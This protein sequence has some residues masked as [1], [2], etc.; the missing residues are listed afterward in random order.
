MKLVS[1]LLLILWLSG[2]AFGQSSDSQAW[3]TNDI[4]EIKFNKD[5][6]KLISNS[7]GDGWLF[8]WDVQGGRLIWRNKTGFIQRGD[9]Y[10]TLTSFAFS[11]D[12][13]YIASGSGNGTV[14]LWDA[15]TGHL[16]W[17]TDAH[18]SNV[19]IVQF[20]PDGKSIISAATP[21]DG[22]DEVKV[23]GVEYGQIIKK[24]EGKPCTVIA[25]SFAEGGKILR[26]GNLDGQIT[27][28][29]LATGKP[30][31]AEYEKGCKLHRT[32]EWESSFS[33]D[34]SLSA[35]RT[36]EKEVTLSRTA[37][38]IKVLE[39]AGYRI[40]SRFS[41]DGT[42]LIVSE[43][44]G[45]TFYDLE[46]G[47]SRK[48]EEFSRTRST[49]DLSSDGRWFAEGGSYGD[50]A[51]KITN[52]STGE[53][54]FVGKKSSK[55]TVPRLVSTALEE[56]LLAE[57][58]L[59]QVEIGRAKASRDQQ[60]AVD[61]QKLKQQVFITFEHFGDMTD[62]GEKRMVESDE[63]KE[64]K[65]SKPSEAA[66]AVWLR[67]TND[68]A[69]PI[70]IPTQSMYLPNKN[71]SFELK[72]G[73]KVFGL[74]DKREIS[75]WHGLEDKKGK[76]VPY[77]FDFGSNAIL[78]PQ[79]SALFPV[80]RELLKEGKV[81]RFSFTF[82]NDTVD[83]KVGDYGEPIVLRFGEQNLPKSN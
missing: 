16:I 7:A 80:P 11:P 36:G 10:Y 70:E 34:L 20:A 59:K 29:E 51:I 15:N 62:P 43:Y 53:S 37:K 42:K 71:C 83:N 72:S 27:E 46:K 39:A 69:L 61:I 9:E 65:I 6:T 31:S 60:A 75:I 4:T 49:I 66:N 63:P 57:R 24:L 22:D 54:R 21:E 67:L 64:S 32:Y 56:R 18:T 74:C 45:F 30:K 82:Q 48:I 73:K 44:G 41:A 40:Y 47:T 55:N 77:G 33:G 76:Q 5:A 25:I 23:I 81:I 2:L 38:P 35:Q 50:A 17:R 13:N 19:T 8:L 3:H 14:A 1:Y 28:W 52:V 12:E 68:S 26:T 58:K 78:L 79:T